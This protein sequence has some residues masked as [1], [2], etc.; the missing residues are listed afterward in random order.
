MKYFLEA[1]LFPPGLIALAVLTGVLLLRTHRRI[2]LY[3]LSAAALSLYVLSLP[4]T[5]SAMMRLLQIYPALSVDDIAQSDAQ[6]IV[7]LGAGRVRNAPEYGGD[8]LAPLALERLRYGVRLHRQTQLPLIISGGSPQDDAVAEADLMKEAAVAEFAVPVMSTEKR[9]K[10]TWENAKYSATLLRERGISRVYLVT[11]AW[12]M[13][14]A[15]WSFARAGVEI[16]PAPTG[17]VGAEL[18][19]AQAWLPSAG[20]LANV[21]YVMH[22]ITGLIWYRFSVRPP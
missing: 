1:F 11:H 3:V 18:D 22:E 13:P 4:A 16:I 6:A 15:A 17:F 20:A 14:R 2:G 8:T 5:A 19:N 7:V 10:T 9:S 21:R 12:H